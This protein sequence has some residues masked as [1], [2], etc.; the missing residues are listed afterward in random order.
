MNRWAIPSAKTLAANEK[1]GGEV[2][3]DDEAE[4]FCQPK[5]DGPYV[6]VGV[7]VAGAKVVEVKD[8][9]APEWKLDQIRAAAGKSETATVVE[10]A[11]PFKAVGPVPKSGTV[12]RINLAGH[13]AE[14]G[15]WLSAAPASG[16]FHDAVTFMDLVFE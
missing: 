6:H 10:M 16:S 13:E 7:N 15:T 4:V 2:W 14:S 12:W 3:N 8:G 5:R 1:E 9:D 11:I